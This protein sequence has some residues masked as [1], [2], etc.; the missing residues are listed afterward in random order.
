MTFHL[1]S[2]GSTPNFITVIEHIFGAVTNF[3]CELETTQ[4][5]I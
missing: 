1:I 2:D 4:G 3:L 5:Q